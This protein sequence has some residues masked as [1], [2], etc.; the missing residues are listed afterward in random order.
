MYFYSYYK[1]TRFIDSEILLASELPAHLINFN[2][3]IKWVT[4]TKKLVS[5]DE[6]FLFYINYYVIIIIVI[7][8][9]IIIIIIKN[10]GS[11][12][13]GESD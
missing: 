3:N 4:P 8:I 1:V 7:I 2:F 5:F 12:R 9:I 13:L 10:V 11:A 6:Y